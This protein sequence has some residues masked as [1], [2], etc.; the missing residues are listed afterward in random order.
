[1]KCKVLLH[2]YSKNG[3]TVLAVSVVPS[4]ANIEVIKASLNVEEFHPYHLAEEEIVLP[5]S[6]AGSTSELCKL[7]SIL[8][9]IAQIAFSH[10]RDKALDE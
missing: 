8:S 4:H 1:M 2:S 7:D 6:L 3:R 5:D 10:G 9:R